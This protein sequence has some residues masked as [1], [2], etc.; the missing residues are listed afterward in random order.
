MEERTVL[1]R[2]GVAGYHAFSS[3]TAAACYVCGREPDDDCTVTAC[4]L[5][6]RTAL[7]C[8]AHRAAG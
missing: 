8:D 6:G 7:F 2:M 3:A 4:T 5:R 1:Q